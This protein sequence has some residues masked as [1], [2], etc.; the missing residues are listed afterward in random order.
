M[1]SVFFR[2]LVVSIPMWFGVS[3]ISHAQSD[4][5]D[6]LNGQVVELYKQGKYVEATVIAERALALAKTRF[7]RNHPGVRYS[8]Y[9][10][11]RI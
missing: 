1:L 8:V 2:I 7:G 3:A 4:D 9:N 11:A 5:V 10:L 6:A